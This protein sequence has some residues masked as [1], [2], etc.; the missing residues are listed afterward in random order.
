MHSIPLEIRGKEMKTT[1]RHY[2]ND[3]DIKRMKVTDN[4]EE[5]GK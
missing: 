3:Y 4:G 1:K 5:V 2:K